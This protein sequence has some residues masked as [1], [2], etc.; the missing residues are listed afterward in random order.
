MSKDKKVL[1]DARGILPVLP[2]LLGS[3]PILGVPPG[4]VWERDTPRSCLGGGTSWSC[5]GI[6][7]YSGVG[8]KNEIRTNSP[9]IKCIVKLPGCHGVELTLAVVQKTDNLNENAIVEVFW[10]NGRWSV[11][12]IFLFYVWLPISHLIVN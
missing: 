12:Y 10:M 4:F 1:C 5:L 9:L 2:S 7:Q 3:G 11:V 8:G 6:R